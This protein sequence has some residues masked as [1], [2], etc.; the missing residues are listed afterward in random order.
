VLLQGDSSLAHPYGL[1]RREVDSTVFLDMALWAADESIEVPFFGRLD[2][3]FFALQT[4]FLPDF[5]IFP[6]AFLLRCCSVS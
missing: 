1:P 2:K 5:V 6:S 3:H 4:I